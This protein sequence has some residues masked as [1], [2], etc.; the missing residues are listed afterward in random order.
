MVSTEILPRCSRVINASSDTTY[1]HFSAQPCAPV[2]LFRRAY[3]MTCKLQV[4][5]AISRPIKLRLS[6][7]IATPA[8]GRR[9]WGE[10]P[11]RP[12][13]KSQVLPEVLGPEMRQTPPDQFVSSR[14]LPRQ[15]IFRPEALPG[16]L[17]DHGK[18][19]RAAGF[20]VDKF[21]RWPCVS[22]DRTFIPHLQQRLHHKH[23]V[24]A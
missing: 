21:K 2:Y 4:M 20:S 13:A 6:F 17:V 10:R 18:L 22:G 11:D 9:A 15:Q 12:P 19:H 1:L 14:T 5:F 24:P 23:G 16:L 8:P 3:N 7:N